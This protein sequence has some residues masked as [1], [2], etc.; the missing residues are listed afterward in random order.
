[1]SPLTRFPHRPHLPLPAIVDIE[2]EGGV[3]VDVLIHVDLATGWPAAIRA[4]GLRQEPE[5]LPCALCQLPLFV[6]K[7]SGREGSTVERSGVH[8]LGGGG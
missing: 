6:L 1:M 3:L 7:R 4:R 5:G 8:H 2:V